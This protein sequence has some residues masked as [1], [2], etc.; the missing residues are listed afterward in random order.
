VVAESARAPDPS[1]VMRALAFVTI[2]AL[3][4]GTEPSATADIVDGAIDGPI[5]GA[6]GADA[7]DGP[8]EP[9]DTVVDEAPLEIG[10]IATE[11]EWIPPLVGHVTDPFGPRADGSFHDA[12]D[13]RGAMG[14]EVRAPTDLVVTWIAYQT[15][16]GRFLI[17]ESADGEWRFTFA[18]LSHVDAVEGQHIAKGDVLALVGYSGTASGPHLHFRVEHVT[19]T[20]EGAAQRDAVDPV[21]VFSEAVLAGPPP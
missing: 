11:L 12:V 20:P 8:I 6:T 7:I 13:L 5:D 3:A 2:G 19:R 15:R 16:A 9:P 14:G 21:D 4:C 18:H 10:P 1:I 17:G